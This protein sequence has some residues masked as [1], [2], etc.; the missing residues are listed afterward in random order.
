[1]E[2][3]QIDPASDVALRIRIFA[4]FTA[5]SALPFELRVVRWWVQTAIFLQ[6]YRILWAERAVVGYNSGR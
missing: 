4:I 3:G 6:N 5:A 2:E 1:M